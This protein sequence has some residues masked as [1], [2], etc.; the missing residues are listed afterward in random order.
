MRVSGGF[1]SG[2]NF[3][4]FIDIY[5]AL[6]K[7]CRLIVSIN[8]GFARPPASTKKPLGDC[9]GGMVGWAT[10]SVVAGEALLCPHASGTVT[11]CLP[12]IFFVLCRCSLGVGVLVSYPLPA[13]PHHRGDGE[14][15]A[16]A[17]AAIHRAG[18]L[19]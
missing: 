3:F 14:G 1:F 17:C 16:A 2:K 10:A 9:L 6:S 4:I 19:H 15:A 7:F 18:A 13:Q 11:R 8:F 12:A 5:R